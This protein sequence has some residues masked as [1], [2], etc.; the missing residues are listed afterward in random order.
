MK[1]TICGSIAFFE[2]MLIV[3]DKLEA[4]GHEVDLPPTKILNLDGSSLISKETNLS[5]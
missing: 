1:I 3:K 2:D 5:F 4:L